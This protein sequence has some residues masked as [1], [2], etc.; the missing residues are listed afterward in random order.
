MDPP[1]EI[2]PYYPCKVALIGTFVPVGI[3]TIIACCACHRCWWMPK[4]VRDGSRKQE[5]GQSYGEGIAPESLFPPTKDDSHV[6]NLN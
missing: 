1:P 4:K 2:C 6:L 5:N 3:L